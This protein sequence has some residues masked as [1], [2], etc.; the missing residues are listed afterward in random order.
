[1]LPHKEK[2]SRLGFRLL[3]PNLITGGLDRRE[4]VARADELA[5]AEARVYTL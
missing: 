1:M 5:D 3:E 4:A 2:I